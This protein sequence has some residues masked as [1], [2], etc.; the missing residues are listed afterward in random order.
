MKRQGCKMSISETDIK[1]RHEINKN[2]KKY[3]QHEQSSRMCYRC[4]AWNQKHEPDEKRLP[5]SLWFRI[6]ECDKSGWF[7]DFR[8]GSDKCKLWEGA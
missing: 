3:P 5:I 1:K 6:C 8:R 2:M 4:K 7:L